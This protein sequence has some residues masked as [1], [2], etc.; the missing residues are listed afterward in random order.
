VYYSQHNEA[1]TALYLEIARELRFVISGGSDF[2]GR[3]KPTVKLGVVYQGKGVSDEVLEY[4]RAK[5]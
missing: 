2:H 1:E 5:A 3:S 4:L